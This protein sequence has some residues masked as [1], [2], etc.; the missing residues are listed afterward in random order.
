MAGEALPFFFYLKIMYYAIANLDVFF[1]RSKKKVRRWAKT[2]RYNASFGFIPRQ[3]FAS[4]EAYS[5]EFGCSL[6]HDL[7]QGI[8]F[9]PDFSIARRF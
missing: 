3:V 6:I 8:V 9:R 5:R 4:P 7:D 1:S 2:A